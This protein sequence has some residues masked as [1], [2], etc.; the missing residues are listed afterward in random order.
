MRKHFRSNNK[1]IKILKFYTEKIINKIFINQKRHKE[2]KWRPNWVSITEKFILF[3]IENKKSILKEYKYS[4]CSDEIYKQTLAWN[5]SFRHS[6]Y[7]SNDANDSCKRFIDWKRGNPYVFG[8]ELEKDFLAI[9]KTDA[10]F[11]RKFDV[12]KYPDIVKLIQGIH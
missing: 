9:K 11:A 10:I 4:L 1:I 2:Y 7:V 5:S 12:L 3:L 6:L 8:N